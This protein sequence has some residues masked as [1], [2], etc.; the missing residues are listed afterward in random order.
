MGRISNLVDDAAGHPAALPQAQLR[1]G[2][3]Q[4][5]VRRVRRVRHGRE[6]RCVAI[7]HGRRVHELERELDGALVPGV[8]RL[9]DV[10]EKN[11]MNE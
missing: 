1:V 6:E 3:R 8:V 4:R 10:I 9:K 2:H 11:E 7:E 5:R